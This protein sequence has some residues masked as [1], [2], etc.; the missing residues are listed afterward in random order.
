MLRRSVRWAALTTGDPT[1]H[2][3]VTGIMSFAAVFLGI[4]ASV[5]SE[6]EPA[7]AGVQ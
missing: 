3:D 4:I 2:C 1:G 6:P 5:R 7:D